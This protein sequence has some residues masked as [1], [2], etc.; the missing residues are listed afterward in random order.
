MYLVMYEV[1]VTPFFNTNKQFIIKVR[2]VLMG[3]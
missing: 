3:H 1:K 2:S